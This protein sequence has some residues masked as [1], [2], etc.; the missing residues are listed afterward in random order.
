MATAAGVSETRVS[1]SIRSGTNVPDTL[2]SACG[3]WR[4]E[5]GDV[6][7][8]GDPGP[9]RIQVMVVQASGVAGVAAAIA[10]ASAALGKGRS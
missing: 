8:V 9:A 6:R 5:H 10:L 4:D 1:K 2:L 7:L 3:M